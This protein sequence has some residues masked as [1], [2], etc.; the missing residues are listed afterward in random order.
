LTGALASVSGAGV[1][2]V[3]PIGG[4]ITLNSGPVGGFG[5]GPAFAPGSLAAFNAQL[6]ADGIVTDGRVTIAAVDSDSGLG[7]IALVDQSTNTP[8]G[9]NSAALHLESFGNVASISLAS[10]PF[11]VI[12]SGSSKLAF[13]DFAWDNAVSGE[14][15]AWSGLNPGNT[16]T[17]RFQQNGPLGLSEPATFQFVNWNGADWE[18]ISVPSNLASFSSSGEYGLSANVLVPSPAGMAILALGGLLAARRRR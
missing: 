7:L 11:V 4:S 14:A 13:G 15:F 17:W 18:L 9:P 3:A 6:N 5:A 2:T 12:P 16:M 8:G 1:I 10:D